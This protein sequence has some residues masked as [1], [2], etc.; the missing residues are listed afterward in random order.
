[1]VQSVLVRIFLTKIVLWLIVI[2]NTLDEM[3]GVYTQVSYFL[4]WIVTRI[5]EDKNSNATKS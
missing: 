4:N 5:D 2:I 1:M 3:P